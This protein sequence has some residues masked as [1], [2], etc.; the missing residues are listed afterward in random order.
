MRALEQC[1]VSNLERFE[2]IGIICY[3]TEAKF[4]PMKSHYT[5]RM[6]YLENKKK[7]KLGNFDN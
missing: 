3:N 2:I 1:N 5:V 4:D 6:S 7:I